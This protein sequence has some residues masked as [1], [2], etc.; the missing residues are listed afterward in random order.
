MTLF[1][2]KTN[3]HELI[4]D[5]HGVPSAWSEGRREAGSDNKIQS[6]KKE[7]LLG[8]GIGRGLSPNPPSSPSRL[9]QGG[10]V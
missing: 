9:R 4:Q 8:R 10:S 5:E 6:G 1:L 3:I 2:E 7:A